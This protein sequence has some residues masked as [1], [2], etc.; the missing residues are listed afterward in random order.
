MKHPT[1]L[2]IIGL[3]FPNLAYAQLAK[4]NVIVDGTINAIVA[5]TNLNSETAAGL[6]ASPNVLIFFTD[7]LAIGGELR[8]GLGAATTML[9]GMELRMRKYLISDPTYGW[10]FAADAGFQRF[11]ATTF[12]DVN[13]GF[14]LDLFI[15]PNLALS[16]TLTV[17]FERKNN[18]F[19]VNNPDNVRVNFGSSL[20][21]FFN[22]ADYFLEQ[23]TPNLYA[24]KIFLG[25]SFG[26]FQF[27]REKGKTFQ[28]ISFSPNF[29]YLL[30]NRLLLG[31]N[32]N[33]FSQASL[34]QPTTSKSIQGT[35]FARYYVTPVDRRVIFFAEAG[36]GIS[37]TSSTVEFRGQILE[38]VSNSNPVTF[39]NL[40]TDW[41][42]TPLVAMESTIG[43]NITR[44]ETVTSNL[45]IYEVGLQFFLK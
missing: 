30:T 8:F 40:G 37:K 19:K 16:N 22:R 7:K 42:I 33:Y 29:G 27:L 35:A 5:G 45:L 23:F 26:N 13:A 17:G 21:F 24:G 38:S 34:V 4:G 36:T 28:N 18:S 11:E 39:A 14:G 32:F 20:K 44:F 9:T 12:I 31:V 10:F 43:F 2:L 3:L 41:F 6:T 15:H 1:L 25:A